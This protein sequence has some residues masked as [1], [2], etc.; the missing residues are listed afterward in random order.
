MK[1]QLQLQGRFCRTLVSGNES[2]PI[3][4]ADLIREVQAVATQ[5]HRRAL[6]GLRQ[7]FGLD[8]LPESVL[9]NLLQQANGA[10]RESELYQ[11][12]SLK[13]LYPV[14][15]NSAHRANTYRYEF[16]CPEATFIL[17][18]DNPQLPNSWAGSD[19]EQVGNYNITLE[20]P[21]HPDVFANHIWQ[22]SINQWQRLP[23]TEKIQIAL[24]SLESNSFRL[25]SSPS[26][27]IQVW[28]EAEDLS[29][30]LRAAITFL[31]LGGDDI[32]ALSESARLLVQ[33]Y[34]HNYNPPVITLPEQLSPEATLTPARGL[35]IS[36][37]NSRSDLRR[38]IT[39]AQNF[40]LISS[41]RI[42]DE[43]ITE[44][45]CQQ[46]QQLPQRVWILTDLSNR[47]I[48]QLDIRV[49]DNNR[50][51]EEYQRSTERKKACLRMLLNANIPIRSGAFHLKTYISE[52]YAYLGS[53]NI[54]GGNL[55][56]NLEAGV[57]WRN[58]PIHTQLINLFQRFWHQSSQDEILPA[59]NGDGFRLRSLYPS[60]QQED[61]SYPNLLTPYQYKQDL[62]AQLT[63]F[64]GEVRI[65][66][67]QFQ[68]TPQIER[69]LLL[70]DTCV[71]VCNQVAPSQSTLNIQGINHLHAKVT[72]LGDSVAY[73]GGIN[74]DFSN[75][76]L[77]L[78]DLMYKTTNRQEITTIRQK[79]QEQC[80]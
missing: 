55:D 6:P 2:Q 51:R 32:S 34:Q 38:I 24:Q 37:R 27:Q 23:E 8:F 42:E 45:I 44:L 16:A 58:T 49:S 12:S 78:T 11:Y 75:S 69:L 46:A 19:L 14:Y 13:L 47:V 9:I 5:T 21:H 74:F 72:L 18:P 61:E 31:R 3:S 77:S 39:E 1:I 66:T 25:T 65:Y 70:S 54:T 22:E 64:R 29:L 43:E 56:F 4:L 36:R 33:Q 79:M 50:W 68:P 63:T 7:S 26:P 57:A 41:Y 53:C 80:S 17:T 30:D 60:P 35:L 48:Q 76:Y 15:S 59:I 28:I 62:I 67:R 10:V 40:L 20:S 71:F 52:R 73:I